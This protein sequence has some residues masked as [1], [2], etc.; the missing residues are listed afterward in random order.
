[1]IHP[2][3]FRPLVDCKVISFLVSLF[4]ESLSIEPIVD[5]ALSAVSKLA[6]FN[7][8]A[9]NTNNRIIVGLMFPEKMAFDA[10]AY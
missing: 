6:N 9:D 8:E 7:L 1:M 10:V 3:S 4:K 5:E 2:I